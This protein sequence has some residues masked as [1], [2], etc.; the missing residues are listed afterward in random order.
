[1][2]IFSLKISQF[3]NRYFTK[4]S[5]TKELLLWLSNLEPDCCFFKSNQTSKTF[6]QVTKTRTVFIESFIII[7]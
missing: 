5:K 3:P 4:F 1:M 7:E 2:N 6:L